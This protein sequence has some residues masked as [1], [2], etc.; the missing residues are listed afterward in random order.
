LQELQSHEWPQGHHVLT[1]QQA[2]AASIPHAEQVILDVKADATDKVTV[3]DV[4]DRRSAPAA[5]E[6]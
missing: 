6:R 1:V 2:L 3:T 5:D 4:R